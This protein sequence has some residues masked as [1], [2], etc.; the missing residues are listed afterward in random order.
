MTNPKNVAT[1]RRNIEQA[2][3]CL[4]EALS[5]VV[6]EEDIERAVDDLD[7]ARLLVDEIIERIR[8]GEGRFGR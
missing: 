2:K 1:L 5:V 8:L 7:Q 4:E 3:H 6:H